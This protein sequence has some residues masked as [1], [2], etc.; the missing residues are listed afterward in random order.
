MKITPILFETYLKCPTKCFLRSLGETGSGNA[1]AD[2]VRTQHKT[3][4]SAGIK[5]VTEGIVGEGCIVAMPEPM[6]LTT[7]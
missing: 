5:H 2:W 1:Y 6:K 7:A 3:C 4:R